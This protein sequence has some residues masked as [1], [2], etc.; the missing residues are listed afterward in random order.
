MV[1]DKVKI[2]IEFKINKNKYKQYEYALQDF[3]N[4]LIG[5]GATATE[6]V[7]HEE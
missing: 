1:E 4:E 6:I 3:C 7:I 2:N 5:C